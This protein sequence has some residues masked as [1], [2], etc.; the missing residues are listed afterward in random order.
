MSVSYPDSLFQGWR[1]QEKPPKRFL[2]R[3][4]SGRLQQTVK[5]R[6]ASRVFV[7]VRFLVR[8]VLPFVEQKLPWINFDFDMS[9][10]ESNAVVL[11]VIHFCG[12][13]KMIRPQAFEF[14]LNFFSTSVFFGFQFKFL[15]DFFL[16]SSLVLCERNFLW[17]EAFFVQIGTYLKGD[18]GV[19]RFV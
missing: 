5:G 17:R 10:S 13:M 6:I 15:F 4:T 3:E 2:Q 7:L 1:A 19:I 12:E 11:S 16:I 9:P 18:C 8:H 14:S